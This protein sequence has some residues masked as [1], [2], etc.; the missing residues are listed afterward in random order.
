[1]VSVGE[2]TLNQVKLLIE[3]RGCSV[4]YKLSK[5]GAVL[6][7]D[8]E[9]LIKKISFNNNSNNNSSSSGSNNI[10]GNSFSIIGPPVK[11]YF[12]VREA[13]YSKFAFITSN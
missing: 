13:L 4:E 6:I 3:Q 11:A 7:C 12:E 1:V 8:G 5:S 2:L 10:S 9:V